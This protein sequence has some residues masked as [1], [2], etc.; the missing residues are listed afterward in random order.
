M[1]TPSKQFSLPYDHDNHLENT[2]YKNL[3]IEEYLDMDRIEPD[4]N[5][6]RV[7]GKASRPGIYDEKDH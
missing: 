5:F 2:L 4:W 7:H 6:A 1:R 3:C